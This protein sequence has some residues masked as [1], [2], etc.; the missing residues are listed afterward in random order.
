MLMLIRPTAT[1]KSMWIGRGIF[2]PT[3]MRS[4]HFTWWRME[5][6]GWDI[7]GLY[8]FPH[9][10]MHGDVN[11]IKKIR[12][13]KSHFVSNKS[14]HLLTEL[15]LLW[16]GISANEVENGFDFT[17]TIRLMNVNDLCSDWLLCITPQKSIWDKM[18]FL[19]LSK[20]V[21]GMK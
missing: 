6:V 5:A 12:C 1:L 2:F 4:C 21:K 18:G 11:K 13:G 8:Y 10:L 19:P 15:H 14:G 3:A 16:P 17:L 7:I 9:S 20:V